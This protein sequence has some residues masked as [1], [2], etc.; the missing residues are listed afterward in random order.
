[1]RHDLKS[2]SLPFSALDW[3]MFE[4]H[5]A[6][7]LLIDP[8]S[9]CIVQAN[10]AACEFYQYSCEKLTGLRV[11]DIDT[12][13]EQEIRHWMQLALSADL[14]EREFKH[15][16]ASGEVRNVQVY[17]GPVKGGG[18]SFLCWVVIDITERKQAERQLRQSEE[19][20]TKIFQTTP[21]VVVISRMTD[22]VLLEVNPGFEAVTGY[23][24]M[25]AIG[26]STLELG[27]WA[28]PSERE[29]MVADLRLYGQVL[30]QLFNFRRKDGAVRIGQMSVR[31][32]TLND[33]PCVLFVMQDVTESQQS[34]RELKASE[35]RY[36]LLFE[37]SHDAIFVIDRQSGRYLAANRAAEELTGRT[38]AD[39]VQLTVADVVTTEPSQRLLGNEEMPERLPLGEVRYRRPAGGS[40][41]ALLSLVPVND[42]IMFGIAQDITEIK[43]ARQRIEHL[44]YYD[45]LTGLPNR[46]LL[47]QRAEWA[48]ALAMRHG[49]ELAVLFLDVD[50]FKEV[51]DALGHSEGDA[52]LAEVAVRL[53]ALVRTADMVCRIGGD[54]FVLLLP[55]TAQQ[56]AL[57]VADKVLAAFREPYKVTGHVLNVS[58]SIGI[59][60]YPRDG[61]DFNDLL[62]NADTAL[63]RVKQ[64]GRNACLSYDR[65]MNAAT[66]ERLMVER[67]LRQAIGA[68]QLRAYYQ[69]KVRL[70]DRA[71]IGA[72]ALVRW[73]HPE[74]GLVPPGQFIPVAETSDLIVEL[75][76][77]MLE[78]VCRQIADWQAR[79]WVVPTV[80]VNLAARHFRL[81]KLVDRV[82]SL[83]QA[84]GLPPRLLE[85]E[86]TE[87]TLL[88]VSSQTTET[89]R[90]LEQLGVGLALDDFGTGYSSLSY[91][92]RLPLTALKIDQSFVR[93]LVTD[94]D[95]RTLAATI[96]TLGH[97]MDLVVVAEGVETEEQR[98][99]LFEQGCDL[100]QGYLFG[101][102]VPASEFIG[103][104][105]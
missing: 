54:E 55:D 45:V 101:R 21:N 79:G 67:D 28:E 59:A 60:L 24:R 48:L 23:S 49:Q 9:G 66:L 32:I 61:A 43:V 29:R 30:Y 105:T 68:G 81:P 20:F 10:P 78:E 47:A 52:L 99:I 69:P 63:Y 41:T 26:H 93:D 38:A 14:P 103:W 2:L 73:Q 71:V 89:L 88:E 100:A 96:V 87:S 37:R 12:L 7:K 64:Q 91:L 53:R 36:R 4:S 77:W 42:A 56:G 84:Y 5:R 39:L 58:V 80:S 27:L 62:K 46:A 70:T 16:L 74:R 44:A 1:M 6:I 94:S 15:R 51:N 50:H 86:I 85:L 35:E 98:S 65:E 97:Y 75:G 17:N 33:E 13:G 31:P 22:A 25:E 11:W 57:R 8:E 19:K 102:P 76:D 18:L 34:Q 104:L 92:K 72:E 40:R 83:L 90:A 3:A 95:D 82:D